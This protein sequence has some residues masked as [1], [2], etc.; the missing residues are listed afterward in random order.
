MPRHN[1]N[2]RKIRA[3][4]V[5]IEAGVEALERGEFTEIDDADLDRYLEDLAANADKQVR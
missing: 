3:L 5:E 4:R 1:V 2:S